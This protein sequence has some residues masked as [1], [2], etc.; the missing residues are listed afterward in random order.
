MTD[1]TS[2]AG[3]RSQ[4]WA[5]HHVIEQDRLQSID[6]LCELRVSCSA[7]SYSSHRLRDSCT[8]SLASNPKVGR[9]PPAHV[10]PGPQPPV[11]AVAYHASISTTSW[12]N[13]ICT[14]RPTSISGAAYSAR[15]RAMCQECSAVFSR[16]DASRSGWLADHGL[17]PID[18]Q[19]K[20]QLMAHTLFQLLNPF[21]SRPF[22]QPT[23]TLIR[24]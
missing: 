19:Q 14:T 13:N 18:L 6:C 20:A 3:P 4:P 22:P 16:R 24:A 9:P 21:H 23:P 8:W 12:S 7:P 15:N 11:S 2:P 10:R 17:Q 5:A 1:Q